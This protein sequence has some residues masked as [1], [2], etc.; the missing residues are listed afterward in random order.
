MNLYKKGPNS[1]RYLKKIG[2][3]FGYLVKRNVK[4]K[5]FLMFENKIVGY[6]NYKNK[7]IK[8]FPP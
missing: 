3:F 6:P 5:A 2:E 4:D 8:I 1:S 7:G